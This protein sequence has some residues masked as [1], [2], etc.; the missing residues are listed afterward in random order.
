MHK[1]ALAAV[2]ICNGVAAAGAYTATDDPWERDSAGMP[3]RGLSTG[4]AT[5][6]GQSVKRSSSVSETSQGK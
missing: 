2:V 3:T 4:E 1:F 5:A 6:S